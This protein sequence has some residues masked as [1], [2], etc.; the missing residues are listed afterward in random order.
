MISKSISCFLYY[1]GRSSRA[2]TIPSFH[3]THKCPRSCHPL[4]RC[5]PT[6]LPDVWSVPQS[7]PDKSI[8]VIDQFP[9]L[10]LHMQ[11]GKIRKIRSVGSSAS[12]SL[13]VSRSSCSCA[14]VRAS[15]AGIPRLWYERGSAWC[16]R[17]TVFPNIGTETADIGSLGTFHAEFYHGKLYFQNLDCRQIHMSCLPFHFFARSGQLIELFPLTFSAEYM[18]GIWS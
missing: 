7:V 2:C 6:L 3:H 5:A 17:S 1:L 8:P 14:S 18:G 12:S 9:P 13:S 16:R 4:C 15:A 11:H 10:F